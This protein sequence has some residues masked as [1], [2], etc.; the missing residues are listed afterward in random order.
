MMLEKHIEQKVCDYARTKNVLAYKFTSPSHM[1]V[2][3]R[4]FICDGWVF[5]IEF[6]AP[7]KKPT[8]LQSRHHLL[9]ASYGQHVYVVDSV[10]VGKEIIDYETQHGPS[11]YHRSAILPSG[12]N[13]RES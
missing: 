11:K 9:L 5:W 8:P 1:G 4:I 6:K 2:C 10:E 7:G 12:C 13:K 3:D